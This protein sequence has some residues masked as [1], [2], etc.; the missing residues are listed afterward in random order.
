MYFSCTK[1]KQLTPLTDDCVV[2]INATARR[3]AQLEAQLA[4]R[5]VCVC[6]P[7][8]DASHLL[9]KRL[10]CCH[11]LLPYSMHNGT[12]VLWCLEM[13]GGRE[14]GEWMKI[15]PSSDPPL[16]LP[17]EGRRLRAGDNDAAEAS[18]SQ[19]FVANEETLL[20]P[21]NPSSP[22][23]VASSEILQ[24]CQCFWAKFW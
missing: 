11:V 12:T 3:A 23:F 2:A 22:P 7:R 24:T 4:V 8:Q 5:F 13:G 20:A 18:R 6:H 1:C 14:R 10:I 19:F 16:S 15:F 21:L 17:K 9:A